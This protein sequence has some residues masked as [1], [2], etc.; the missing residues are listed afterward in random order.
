LERFGV[1]AELLSI[2]RG[3]S[4]PGGDAVMIARFLRRGRG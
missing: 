4:I 1:E 2:P 3:F